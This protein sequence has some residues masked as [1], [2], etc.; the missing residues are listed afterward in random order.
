M[1]NKVAIAFL[2]KYPKQGTL[3]F[4]KTVAKQTSFDV[5]VVVDDMEVVKATH[6]V[7]VIQLEDEYCIK[8]HYFN[9]N[10][11]DK[12]THIAKNPIAFDKF[13]FHFCKLNQQYDFVWVFED[14]VF[15]PSVQTIVD[16]HEKCS[17]YD[18]ATPN[19]FAKTDNAMDWHWKHVVDKIQ[20]PY[21]Y[22]MVCGMG[23]S[24]RMLQK[25]RDYAYTNK[26]LFYIEV[27]FNTLAMQSGFSVIT[28]LE[29]KSIVWQGDFGLNEWL[30]LPN[31]VFHPL[32][33]IDDHEYYRQTIKKAKEIGY[34][35][36]NKL[37]PFINDLLK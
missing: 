24:K 11:S 14:D 22:S 25:I 1:R 4:A 35:P 2:T 34:Q 26:T 16:L 32:K 15:I 17:A 31:N 27:M 5:Y 29:L 7:T 19:N 10:I 20:P 36:V 9:S 21:H 28:P 23:L 18:L 8:N 12:A 6:N 13:L 33:D 30:L 37:P 3:D